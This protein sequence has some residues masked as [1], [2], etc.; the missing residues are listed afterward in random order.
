MSAWKEV[1]DFSQLW[2]DRHWNGQTL[3]EAKML[4][5]M[6]LTFMGF[7]LSIFPCLSR[8][9]GVLGLGYTMSRKLRCLNILLG[10]SALHYSTSHLEGFQMLASACV[11][12][13]TTFYLCLSISGAYQ[14]F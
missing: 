5:E 13:L 4:V 8:R 3:T 2:V 11:L 10:V 7:Q 12:C 6:V 14:K 9:H 1:L